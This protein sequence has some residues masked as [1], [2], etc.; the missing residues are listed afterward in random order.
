M[1]GHD[2]LLGVNTKHEVD[3]PLFSAS[4]R[5]ASF[6]FQSLSI[7]RWLDLELAHLTFVPVTQ[8]WDGPLLGCLAESQMHFEACC[9]GWTLALK[10]WL[11]LKTLFRC[12]VKKCRGRALHDALHHLLPSLQDYGYVESYP[13][14]VIVHQKAVALR[15][16]FVHLLALL[17]FV[18]AQYG[19]SWPGVLCE[20]S[21]AEDKLI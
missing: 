7:P 14:V 16:K 3:V 12:L 2:V 8:C 4:E 20:H 17:T 21:I 11:A 10:N 13:T 9:K 1:C 15:D 6:T 18:L 19:T 5:H